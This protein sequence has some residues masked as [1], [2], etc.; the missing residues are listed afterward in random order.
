MWGTRL[1]LPAHRVKAFE[2][3]R[4][5]PMYALANMGHPSRTFDRGCRS[6]SEEGAG[7]LLS[8]VS[9]FFFKVVAGHG[10]VI[11]GAGGDG[12]GEDLVADAADDLF[13]E[14][15]VFAIHST[16]HCFVPDGLHRR[17]FASAM[18]LIAH[19]GLAWVLHLLRRDAKLA[20]CGCVMV[21]EPAGF[22]AALGQCGH[23]SILAAA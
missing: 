7:Y 5:R 1:L 13:S 22:S 11:A 15:L 16:H 19:H 18:G 10:G 17:R 4:F 12:D 3:F 2:E 23:A 6:K 21:D 9:G 20:G 8:Y 14:R